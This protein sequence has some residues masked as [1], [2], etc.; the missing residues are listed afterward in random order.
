MPKS[1]KAPKV[2][3][4]KQDKEVVQVTIVAIPGVVETVAVPVGN[5]VADAAKAADIETD[6]YTVRI[7]GAPGA[8]DS[9]LNQGDYVVLAPEVESN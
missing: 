2:K 4:S 8:L 5:T 7:N 9:V 6:G 3:A 1:A